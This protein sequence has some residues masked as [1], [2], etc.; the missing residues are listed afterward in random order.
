MERRING[1]VKAY[2][3]PTGFIPRYEDLSEL[4]K[5]ELASSYSKDDYEVQFATRV[6][7]LLEKLDISER[8]YKKET[9]V[10]PKEIL[11][12]IAIQRGLLLEA[13]KTYGDKISPF[14]FEDYQVPAALTQPF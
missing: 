8:F 7:D 3:T 4:F 1:K 2:A 5:K 12:M 11:E 9:S 14:K 10:V 13:Q 6:P